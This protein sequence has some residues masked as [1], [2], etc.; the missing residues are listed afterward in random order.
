MVTATDIYRYL[1][2][3]HWPYWERFGDPSERRALT[4]MEEQRLA[5]GLDHEKAIVEKYWG[6]PEDVSVRGADDPAERTLALMREGAPVIYQG[7]LENERFSG[8][9]DILERHEGKSALG[10][11]YYAPVDIKRSHE[12]KKEHV[13]QVMV[14]AELLKD[15]Q[16]VYPA[17]LAIVNGDGERLPIDPDLYMREFHE[18]VEKVEHVLGGECPEPVYRKTCEDVSPWGKACFRLA[19][20]RDDIA[21]LFSVDQKK[22]GFLRDHG[23]RTIYDAADMDPT[24]LEGLEPGMTLRALQ[25]IQRQA[26]SLT[27]GQVLIRKPWTH[28]TRG[29]EIH[30]DIESHPMTDTDYLYG[31]WLVEPQGERCVSFVAESPEGEGKMWRSFMEWLPTLPGDYTVYHYAAYETVRLRALA[32]RYGDEENPWLAKFLDSM[33]DLKEDV[34]DYVT[35]PLYFYS[36]KR[37]CQFLGFMWTSE[38]KSGGDSIGA[39]EQFLRTGDRSILE[40]LIRYNCDDTRA[41]AH[42]LK[43]MKTYAREETVYTPP[44]PWT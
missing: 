42:L 23:I 22:L 3:P 44:F 15:L 8:R 34:R 35:F 4:E 27:E 38:V 32:K 6:A 36:L 25:F 39:Y 1:Q 5:D 16:G 2:C 21:L 10:D 26:R 28:E 37:I 40:D 14:Y 33:L 43:W 31:F 18:V 41:T 29:L 13:F 17:K 7:V 12:L 19:K 20:E 24:S 30:F 11:W 9:P